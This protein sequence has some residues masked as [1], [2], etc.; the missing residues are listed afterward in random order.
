[1]WD[2]VKWVVIGVSIGWLFYLNHQTNQQLRDRIDRIDT[3]R[4]KQTN[5]S[6]SISLCRLSHSLFL[7]VNH[8]YIYIYIYI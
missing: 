1:M 2:K 8:T 3:G 4:K 7:F 6:T 5:L